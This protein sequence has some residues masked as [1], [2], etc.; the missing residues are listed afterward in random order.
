MKVL[1]IDPHGWQK[2]S[3]NLG[4]AY[5]A[6]ALHAA[7][8]PTQ[9]L[10]LNNNTYSD[11][12]LR[13]IISEYNPRVI[14]VSIKTATAN[15][16]AGI[17]AKLK[18]IFP[19]II[20]TA[21]G[22]HI[23]LCGK[24]FMEENKEVNF[25]IAGEGEESF[26]ALVKNIRDET[27]K[28]SKINGLYHYKDGGLIF[29]NRCKHLDIT[30]LSFPRF[31]CI[32]DIDFTGFRYPLLTSRGCPYNCIF[33]CV[34]LIF[35][36]TWRAREPEEIIG[37]LLQA[38]EDY[39]ISSFEIMDDN[40]TF[41]IVRAKK[42][43]A[44]MIKERIGM[45]WWCHNGLRADR[46][47]RELLV[48]MKRAGCKSVALGIES[49]DEEVFSNI[50]KGEKL[51]DIIKAVRMVKK[52]GIKC[53]GY[54][55]IGLPGVSVDSVKKTVKLQRSLG[56]SDFKYNMLVP[57]P[58]TGM[59]KFV[60]RKG[61]MLTDVKDIY[62]FGD[63]IKISFETERVNQETIEK[64]CYLA[65][66][67][68]WIPGERDLKKIKGAF[69]ERFQKDADRIIVI[70]NEPLDVGKYIELEFDKAHLFKIKPETVSDEAY[71]KCALKGTREFSYFDELFEMMR[72]EHEL[73][74]DILKKKF[75]VKKN[76]GLNTEEV[77]G[78]VLP[79]PSEWDSSPK[80]YF[81]C[82]LKRNS[83]DTLS[84]KN[85]VIYKDNIALPF[86]PNPQSAKN[87]CAKIEAGLA[88]ISTRAYSASSAY[89]ADYLSV[90]AEFD[91]QEVIIRGSNETVLEKIIDEADILFCPES[92]KYLAL[93]AS[94]AGMNVTYRGIGDKDIPAGYREVGLSLPGGQ[95]I[96][97]DISEMLSSIY[98][99]V[100]AIFPRLIIS[101]KK[102]CV[103]GGLWIQ[104][105]ILI[106]R[107]NIR[108]MLGAIARF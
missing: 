17:I 89:S 12:E 8:F 6:S 70:A 97:K 23:T 37:E 49:G 55:V 3:W 65:D 64:C 63:N 99:I 71:A 76:K 7:G 95:Y 79:N 66:N 87:P 14:G 5:L 57:Y 13:I 73:I 4:L 82:R 78:E 58:G 47:D 50:N 108:H 77:R 20:Y 28:V 90:K 101:I 100:L 88:F 26:L 35:G 46:L 24:E 60:Q 15:A 9:I 86:N 25:G 74:A 84:P 22:P 98:H 83:P 91:L 54:F 51:S 29:N 32:K 38:K 30:K 27:G 81:A 40:F 107:K 103:C 94:K 48:L 102:C 105:L 19:D 67:Q 106:M 44:L 18:N 36:K 75:F 72:P 85:G 1:L 59:W 68:G 31:E 2:H 10:D 61:R 43:C 53:V 39:R 41:D 80:T 104:I 52:A 62:H 33:C 93:V 21:G 42:V 92:L 96:L 45:D 56:L 34:G 69:E 11:E 16:S